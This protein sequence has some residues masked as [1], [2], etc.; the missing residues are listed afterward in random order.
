MQ[1]VSLPGKLLLNYIDT[2][3][4]KI[5][6]KLEVKRGNKHT[7]IRVKDGYVDIKAS[8]CLNN[9]QTKKLLLPYASKLVAQLNQKKDYYLFGKP[10]AA[11]KDPV[12]FYKAYAQGYLK[13]RLKKLANKHCIYPKRVTITKAKT[14]W[15]S[16]SYKNSISLSLFLVKLPEDVIDYVI[17]HELC[18]IKHKSHNKSFWQA[19]QKCCPEYKKKIQTL[20]EFEKIAF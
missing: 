17:I 7:Y 14:R 2:P 4:G 16:C 19:V 9:L 11:P 15:G 1:R 5:E 6:Y 10:I 13:D 8:C 20:R 3:Y 18:H 12:N